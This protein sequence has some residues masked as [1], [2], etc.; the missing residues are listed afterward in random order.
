MNDIGNGRQA[1]QSITRSLEILTINGIVTQRP[2]HLPG[3]RC[4]PD[5]RVMSV[6][7]TAADGP[8][9]GRWT[10]GI[11]RV[12]A[13]TRPGNARPEYA[14]PAV[15]EHMDGVFLVG[16]E[17]QTANII[18]GQRQRPAAQTC[19]PRQERL[20]AGAAQAVI[21]AILAVDDVDAL[22]VEVGDEYVTGSVDADG[23]RKEWSSRGGGG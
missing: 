9:R 6:T 13:D 18:D 11:A 15:A 19:P 1:R 14:R 23:T 21:G 12:A 22:V 2:G 20:T 10:T 4:L 5:A 8:G 3:S 16:D 17:Q 7:V